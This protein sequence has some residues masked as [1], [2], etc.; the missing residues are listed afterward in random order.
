[1]MG[2]TDRQFRVQRCLY[3]SREPGIIRRH[4]D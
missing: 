3:R 4:S 2:I 1:M